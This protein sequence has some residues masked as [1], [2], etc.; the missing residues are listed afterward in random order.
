MLA[1]CW[2]NYFTAPISFL[3]KASTKASSRSHRVE[4]EVLR[5]DSPKIFFQYIW[6]LPQ[7]RTTNLSCQDV[8]LV[9][10]LSQSKPVDK[11]AIWLI[12]LLLLDENFHDSLAALLE[13][14]FARIFLDLRCVLSFFCFVCVCAR[15]LSVTKTFFRSSQPGSYA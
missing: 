9:I 14:L 7:K 4:V 12:L 13:A 10:H 3:A 6:P 1:P 15:P 8:L 11:T 2:S 5:P